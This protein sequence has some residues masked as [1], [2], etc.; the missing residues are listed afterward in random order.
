[1]ILIWTKLK[2]NLDVTFQKSKTQILLLMLQA[3]LV[4]KGFWTCSMVGSKNNFQTFIT[5]FIPTLFKS[6]V[7]LPIGHFN[8]Q[9]KIILIW[10]RLKINL[11]VT[12]QKSKTQVLLLLYQSCL[13]RKGFRTCS[14]VGSKNNFET[15]IPTFFQIVRDFTNRAFFGPK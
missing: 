6:Y 4:C 3:C 7:I 9:M 13:V 14:M 15:F 10:T 8:P 11:D 5:T 2:I 12:F 1:M